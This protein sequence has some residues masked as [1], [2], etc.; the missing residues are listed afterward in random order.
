MGIRRID[1]TLC[2]GCA[3]CV[4][5]CP[6]DVLRM[7]VQRKKAFIKYLEDCQSCFLCEKEC[8]EKAIY[9]SPW[10]E[11]RTPLAW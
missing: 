10:R 5:N 7:D 3:I 1:E 2:N 11:R 9:V 4:D 8:P 6:L